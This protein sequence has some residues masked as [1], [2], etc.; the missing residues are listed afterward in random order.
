MRRACVEPKSQHLK[1]LFRA[2]TTAVKAMARSMG[3]NRTMTGSS[4]VPRPNPQNRV[5]PEARKAEEQMTKYF[6][7]GA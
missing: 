4:K 7:G 5:K 6:T 1:K 2:W 3:K